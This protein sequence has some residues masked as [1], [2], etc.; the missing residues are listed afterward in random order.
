MLVSSVQVSI[1][2]SAHQTSGQ[3]V[4][5]THVGSLVEWGL[6][7]QWPPPGDGVGFDIPLSNNLTAPVKAPI[8]S[9]K[10]PSLEG[11]F[12]YLSGSAFQL[13]KAVDSTLINVIMIYFVLV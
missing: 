7:R 4:C 1:F 6:R 8:P 5:R 10:A 13:I 9:D 12:T 2:A 3:S 11:H